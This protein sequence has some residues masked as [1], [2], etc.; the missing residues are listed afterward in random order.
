MKT[1]VVHRNEAVTIVF[2]V[3]GILLTVRGKALE[4]G[5]VGDLVNVLNIQSNRTVQ[6]EVIGPGQ[7]IIAAT[8]PRYAA[9]VAP[10]SDPNRRRRAQ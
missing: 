4:P 10:S 1:D 8:T 6:A 2:E 5:A 3:P 9:A 7:V